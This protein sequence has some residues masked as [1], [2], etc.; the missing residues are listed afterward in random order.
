MRTSFPVLLLAVVL[1]ACGGGPKEC[2]FSDA[3][4]CPAEQS[5]EQVQGKDKPLCF[6][7]VVLEGRVFD[8]STDVGLK[9]ADVIALDANGA[10]VGPGAKSAPDGKYRLRVPGVRTDDKGAFVSKKV[11]LRAAAQNYVPFPSGTRVSL[12]VDTAGAARTEE[13]KPFVLTGGLSNLG[14][15]ALPAAEQ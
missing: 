1:G 2:S 15:A 11:F 4:S 3:N 13:G 6:A 5:C 8:L 7:P 12:P 14:L 10:A 9:G